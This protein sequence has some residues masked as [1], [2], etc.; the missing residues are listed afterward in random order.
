[1]II[2]S[3]YRHYRTSKILSDMATKVIDEKSEMQYAD[4]LVCAINSDWQSDGNRVQIDKSLSRRRG[5]YPTFT[6]FLFNDAKKVC[7]TMKYN[8]K[9]RDLTAELYTIRSVQRFLMAK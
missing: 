1:M 8:V 5:G 4:A 7:R 2:A 6:I 9:L 3:Y